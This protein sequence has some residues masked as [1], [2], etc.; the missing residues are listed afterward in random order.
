MILVEFVVK[1]DLRDGRGKE[2]KIGARAAQKRGH[3][4]GADSSQYCL[5]PSS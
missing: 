4:I 5:V 2:K 3:M 1:C